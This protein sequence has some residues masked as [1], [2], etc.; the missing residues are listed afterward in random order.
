MQNNAGD[1]KLMVACVQVDFVWT[2]TER[3][4]GCIGG[5]CCRIIG[6]SFSWQR[7]DMHYSP[8]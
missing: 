8:T 6:V 4:V 5:M 3:S 1:T 7:P 2:D